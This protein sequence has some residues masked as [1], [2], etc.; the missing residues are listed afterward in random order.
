MSVPVAHHSTA[1][2]S[3]FIKALSMPWSLLESAAA[4]RSSKTAERLQSTM[5]SGLMHMDGGWL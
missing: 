2:S 3:F 5:S 4:I 1:D